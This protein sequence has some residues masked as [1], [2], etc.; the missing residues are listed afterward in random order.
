MVI[1]HFFKAIPNR[2][3]VTCLAY[4]GIVTLVTAASIYDLVIAQALPVKLQNEYPGL[5]EVASDWSWQLWAVIILAILL[6]A[7]FERAH[8]G[9]S[10]LQQP[11]DSE[12]RVSVALSD[13]PYG[14]LDYQVV[15][16]RAMK[17]SE[18]AIYATA[19][20]A[21]QLTLRLE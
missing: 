19:K 1:K 12:T 7:V 16:P 9:L 14:I 5:I 15:R 13:P 17:R 4:Q 6:I 18:K 10:E 11:V 20:L 2:Q 21:N 8:R 3:G